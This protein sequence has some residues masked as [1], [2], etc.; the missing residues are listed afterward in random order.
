MQV[1]E[2]VNEI[3]TIEELVLVVESVKKV[4]GIAE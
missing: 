3:G 1:V 2:A 4:G